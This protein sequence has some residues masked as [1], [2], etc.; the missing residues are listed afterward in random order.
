MQPQ[1]AMILFLD[2]DGALHPSP[3]DERGI[4]CHWE[5]LESILRMFPFV[6]V[7]ISSS[8]RPTFPADVIMEI[9]SADI[10]SRIVGMTPSNVAGAD[11]SRHAEILAWITETNYC[12]P[13]VALDDAAGEFHNAGDRLLVCQT[14]VGFDEVVA[15]RLME[16]LAAE[17]ARRL[18]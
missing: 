7:V 13:W 12:R 9:F 11:Q 10:Q 3:M 2:F 5:R 16:M 15:R 4:F 6:N 17:Q 18:Q 1:A 14:T 8:W